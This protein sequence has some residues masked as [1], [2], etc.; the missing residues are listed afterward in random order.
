MRAIIYDGFGDVSV[1]QLKDVPFPTLQPG[2]V[3]IKVHASGLNRADLSQR[4]GKYPP[5]AGESDIPGLEIA[6]EV[7]ET[8]PGTVGFRKGD[9]VMALLAGG[10]YSE[11]VCVDTG[12]V[13][14]LPLDM[15]FVEGAATVEA[16]ITAHLNLFQL[17]QVQTG[18]DVLIHAGASG[19]GTAALQ[20]L[21][22]VAGK[23]FA[24]IGSAQKGKACADLGAIPI[25]YKS[26]D[27]PEAVLAHT[28]GKGV[29]LILDP[30]GADYFTQNL[31]A[32]AVGGTIVH[33]GLMGGAKTA[34]DLGVLMH[35]RARLIGSTLR[36]LPLP[37]KRLVVQRFWKDTGSRFWKGPG[38]LRPVVDRIFPADQ[39]REAQARMESNLNV[40]KIVLSWGN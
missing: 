17:G 10:G 6:G 3:R 4:L 26:E 24:T 2:Q 33:I 16:F 23:V 14:P 11:E 5:P 34:L 21:K 37:Q 7:I 12:L 22:S 28:G 36:A 39:A 30:V 35:K 32:L 29:E 20:L 18:Q 25:L 8:F 13:M 9:R 40:G 27:F 15:S 38:N 31:K 19:V 1:I